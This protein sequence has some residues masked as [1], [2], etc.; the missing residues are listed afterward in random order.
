M[1]KAKKGDSIKLEIYDK[2]IEVKVAGI[3]D[4]VAGKEVFIDHA[5]LAGENVYPIE[6][7]ISP[8]R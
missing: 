8:S 5:W 7:E 6:I 1:L 3:S 2:E 4:R